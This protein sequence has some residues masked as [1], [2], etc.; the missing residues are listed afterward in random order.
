M[1]A[2]R[3]TGLLGGT[4]DPVHNGHLHIA[5]SAISEL[6]FDHVALVPCK[7]PVHREQ[8]I[9][10]AEQR[11]AMLQLAVADNPALA[12]NDIELNR[13]LPSYTF[14]T[15]TELRRIDNETRFCCL[16]GVDAFLEFTQWYRW[17]QILELAHLLVIKRPGYQV[18]SNEEMERLLQRHYLDN[19]Q[20]LRQTPVGGIV[21]V[22]L[23][24]PDISA[25][26]IRQ[27][28]ASGADVSNLVPAPVNAWLEQYPIYSQEKIVS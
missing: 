5:Q 16:L 27:R 26:H 2:P 8:P 12:I 10:G 17:R 7:I 13:D 24:A 20:Q 25:T 4:F 18:E 15:L 22:E 28:L 11:L 1:S 21:I 6:G 9:A 3:L 19:V 14:N 23:N